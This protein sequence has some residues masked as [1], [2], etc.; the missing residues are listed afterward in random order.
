M[1]RAGEH[2]ERTGFHIPGSALIAA[3]ML[4]FAANQLLL[5]G[6]LGFGSPWLAA[7]GAAIGLA[8][9]VLASRTH[10]ALPPVPIQRLALLF[11]FALALYALGGEGRFFYANIDWQ[12]RDAVLRDMALAPW[13]FVYATGAAGPDLLRAPIG[14]FLAPAL[15]FK[16]WGLRTGEIALLVQNAALLAILLS[17]GGSLFERTRQRIAALGVITLFSG[18]DL[19]L[20]L[21]VKGRPED[22]LEFAFD[23]MQYSAHITQAFWVPQ[24]AYAG[25]LGALLF[26]LWH[27]GLMPLWPML[28]MLPLTALWSPLPLIGM[29]PFVAWAGLSTLRKGEL[30]PIDFALPALAVLLALPTLLYLSAAPDAVGV[31]LLAIPLAPWMLFEALEVMVWLVPLLLWWKHPMRGPLILAGVILLALPFIQVGWSIDLMM[32]ASIPSLAILSAASAMAL[33]GDAPTKLKLWLGT[34]LLL[35][36]ATGLSE[37]R[38]ALVEPPSPRGQCSFYGAWNVSFAAYPKGSHLAPLDR[39]PAAIRPNDPAVVKVNDP[40][41]CWEGRWL[42]PTGV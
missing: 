5:W 38:R 29:M 37:V 32:R 41:P 22:H 13:P 27:R 1:G 23:W 19:V 42:R 3:L 21:I 28:A 30:R 10:C 12:V 25:W 31:R 26:L 7:A 11:G 35:G 15:A 16:A 39:V 9:A 2:R 17:L 24:H 6:F 34:A 8:L 18:L 20:Q 40:R 4:W 14:F 33:T 36:S